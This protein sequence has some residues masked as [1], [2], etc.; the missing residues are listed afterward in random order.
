MRFSSRLWKMTESC[1]SFKKTES[2][3][4]LSRHGELR[5]AA[6]E[7]WISIDGALA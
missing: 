6:I 2:H 5:A 1:E 4:V 3:V 7:V